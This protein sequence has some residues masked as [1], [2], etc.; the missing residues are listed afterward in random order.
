VQFVGQTGKTKDGKPQ[1][2]PLSPDQAR[3][4]LLAKVPGRANQIRS[5]ATSCVSGILGG[6][7]KATGNFKYQGAPILHVSNGAGSIGCTV[8]YALRPS[9]K[10]Q[11]VKVVAI[12]HHEGPTTYDMDWVLTGAA[13]KGGKPGLPVLPKRIN[14]VNAN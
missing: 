11:A 1:F 2:G 10:V 7:G 8:F 14:L 6:Q 4:S 12:G 3:D 13:S 5:N 9:G